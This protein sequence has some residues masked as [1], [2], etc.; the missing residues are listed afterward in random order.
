MEYALHN[1][2]DPG[3]IG[4]VY[5][6]EYEYLVVTTPLDSVTYWSRKWQHGQFSKA[7]HWKDPH[8]ITKVSYREWRMLGT[9]LKL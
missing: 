2:D 1:Y 3:E 8:I 9:Q 6:K 5:A 7:W 4:L